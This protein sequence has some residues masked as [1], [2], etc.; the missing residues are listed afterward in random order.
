MKQF[1]CKI[2]TLHQ[3]KCTQVH[4]HIQYMYTF[5]IFTYMYIVHWFRISKPGRSTV[6][7][8]FQPDGLL[9]VCQIFVYTN[10]ELHVATV[11]VASPSIP[12]WNI[13]TPVRYTCTYVYI[14]ASWVSQCQGTCTLYVYHE[15]RL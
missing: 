3:F 6:Y 4:V 12:P 10:Q 2:N 8:Q 5:S 14:R 9:H 7:I 13:K 11:Y 1:G 15:L